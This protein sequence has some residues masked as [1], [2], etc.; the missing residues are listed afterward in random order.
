MLTSKPSYLD[1]LLRATLNNA[2]EAAGLA[3]NNVRLIPVSAETY[4]QMVPMIRA[5]HQRSKDPASQPH[6]SGIEG[7]SREL[8]DEINAIEEDL[9]ARKYKEKLDRDVPPLYDEDGNFID[10]NF[11]NRYHHQK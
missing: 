1:N 6:L 8:I 9:A 4:L 7:S 11:Y 2:I 3:A 5:A 10:E